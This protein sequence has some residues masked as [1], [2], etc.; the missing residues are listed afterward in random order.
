M[1]GRVEVKFHTSYTLAP[2]GEVSGELH[3]PLTLA[4]RKEPKKSR[5]DRTLGGPSDKETNT[6]PSNSTSQHTGKYCSCPTVAEQITSYHIAVYL[7]CF[8]CDH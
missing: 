6:S 1:Y 5:L 3:A 8:I 7:L 4:P 2:N